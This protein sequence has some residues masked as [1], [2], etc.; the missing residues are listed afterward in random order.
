MQT[1][2]FNIDIQQSFVT[3]QRI[4]DEVEEFAGTMSLFE[5][6]TW[7]ILQSLVSWGTNESV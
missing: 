4:C 6:G 1:L 7:E 2:G 3:A 5:V